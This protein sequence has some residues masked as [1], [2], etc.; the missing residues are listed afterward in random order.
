M[1]LGSYPWGYRSALTIADAL[2]RGQARNSRSAGAP[3][4]PESHDVADDHDGRRAHAPIAGELGNGRDRADG[5]AL[6]WR[7]AAL[8]DSDRAARRPAVQGEQ[9][10]RALELGDS[11]EQH[12]RVVVTG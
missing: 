8:D 6:V 2:G 7:E 3:V 10:G 11:H 5:R 4:G 1:R 12:Q 9:L